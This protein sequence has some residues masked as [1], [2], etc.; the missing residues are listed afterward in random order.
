MYRL[1][2][3]R[4]LLRRQHKKTVKVFEMEGSNK[5]SEV[6]QKK[7]NLSKDRDLK[8]QRKILYELACYVRISSSNINALK[9]SDLLNADAS[10]PPK[11]PNEAFEALGNSRKCSMSGI[12]KKENV[13]N[14]GVNEKLK[15]ISDVNDKLNTREDLRVTINSKKGPEYKRLKKNHYLRI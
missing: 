1:I 8:L 13:G 11:N 9:T 4:L 6:Q 12:E 3:N 7:D 15:T 10:E 14:F 2:C 5:L